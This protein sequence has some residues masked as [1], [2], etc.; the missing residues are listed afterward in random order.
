MG[1]QESGR[2]DVVVGRRLVGAICSRRKPRVICWVPARAPAPIWGN[3]EWRR[4]ACVRRAVPA[5][6]CLCTLR[7]APWLHTVHRE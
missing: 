5:P 3:A 4:A 1:S 2:G 7:S 6:E